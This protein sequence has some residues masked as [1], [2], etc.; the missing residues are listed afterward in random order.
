MVGVFAIIGKQVATHYEKLAND[1]FKLNL[2]EDIL[3]VLQKQY[4]AV[5]GK[6]VE[7]YL[8][9]YSWKELAVKYYFEIMR[10]ELSLNNKEMI[11]NAQDR[12]KEGMKL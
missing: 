4:F 12:Q 8:C 10:I 5:C 2:V 9:G 1:I 7:R 3:K 6:D 11:L